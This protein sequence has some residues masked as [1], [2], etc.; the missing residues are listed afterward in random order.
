MARILGL[1]VDAHCIR[2]A[3]L[4]AGFRGATLT[5]LGY[6]DL[7]PFAESKEVAF[8][9][10]IATILAGHKTPD[11]V[12]A[13]VDGQHASLRSVDLAPGLAGKVREVLPLELGEILP[14]D[15]SDVVVDHQVERKSPKELVVLATAVKRDDVRATLERYRDA[16]VE[17]KELAVGAAALDGLVGL[18][19]ALG[20]EPGPLLLLH[21]ASESTDV[22]VLVSGTTVLARTLSIGADRIDRGRVDDLAHEVSRTIAALRAKGLPA[23]T[24][25]RVTGVRN[26]DYVAAALE[27]VLSVP[28]TALELPLVPGVDSQALPAFARAIALAGRTTRK[29]RRFDLRQ[30]EFAPPRAITGL[31]EHRGKLIF[32]ALMIFAGFFF[33]IYVRHA[34]VSAE[35]EALT[36]RLRSVTREYFGRE[37]ATL[38]EAQELRRG[39][40]G[41]ADP[42]PTL[43]ALAVLDLISGKIPASVNH[44]T[45]R[46][47]IEIDDEAREGSFEISGVVPTIGDRD[48]IAT[49]LE[50]HEC[51]TQV[52]RGP[53]TPAPN[54]GGQNYRLEG[55]IKCPSDE[56][57]AAAE[58]A[59]GGGN[60]GGA[61]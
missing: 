28:S 60:Q 30:G 39:E 4:E 59:A 54:N 11:H 24:G 2:A 8:R 12:V 41:L 50:Q 57:A 31:R 53:M 9:Q 34:A 44:E 48:T 55:A 21:V 42:R 26:P 51:V 58:P 22:C 45:Y 35:N 15:V 6:A 38:A 29:G 46:L 49:Q 14:F 56:E 1:D 20:S 17:P 40:G 5:G 16:G 10:A 33:S 13:A 52:D 37:A 32:G 19:P 18:S 43:D 23:P 25:I 61:R 27:S 3:W 36:V 47:R 7:D